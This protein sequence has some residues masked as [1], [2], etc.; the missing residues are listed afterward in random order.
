MGT[1]EI[2]TGV[3]AAIEVVAPG[4]DWQRIEADRP[5]R[6]QVDL[7]SLDW[8]NFIAEIGE[9]MTVHIPPSDY[10]K[11]ESLNSVV[12]YL[13]A[14]R[15]A[16]AVGSGPIEVQSVASLPCRQYVLNGTALTVRP[17]SHEDR[18]LE[19]D[20]VRHLSTEARYKRFM[21]T[22][23]EL[24]EAKLKYLTEVDQIGHIALV[25][26]RQS[27]DGAALLGVVRYVVDATGSN[28]EFAIAIDDAWKGSGLAGILMH[29][30]MDVARARGLKT[31]EGIVLATNAHMLK[32]T[33]QLGFH[34]A[35]DP[36]ERDVVR[37]VRN[38]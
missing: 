28:C 8:L 14:A 37:V 7:D 38:L 1:D 17:I 16:L 26:V 34:G 5:L 11:L 32:F 10:A 35:R 19:A 4:T 20:F 31:M 36:E 27:D 9:R 21:V 24:P 23:R 18:E 13:V 33:R 6:E 30:L 3:R 12:A 15:A 22:L 29:E 25:A 2:L